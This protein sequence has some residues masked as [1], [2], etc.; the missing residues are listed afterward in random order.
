[1]DEKW[2][3]GLL[4]RKAG[5]LLSETR[6][7]LMAGSQVPLRKKCLIDSWLFLESGEAACCE[8]A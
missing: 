3:Y 2:S 6:T 8:G 1:M 5:V 7:E 4:I